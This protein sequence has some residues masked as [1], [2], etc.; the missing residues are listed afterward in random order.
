MDAPLVALLNESNLKLK[1]M[2]SIDLI[3]VFLVHNGRLSA[4][5]F[6]CMLNPC[7]VTGLPLYPL[8]PL[9]F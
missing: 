7:H 6:Q 2:Q 8:K 1:V 3:W 9:G 5:I 4:I